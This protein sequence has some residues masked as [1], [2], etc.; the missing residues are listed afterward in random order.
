MMTEEYD[1][2]DG[3]R[4]W[5]SREEFARLLDVV[6]EPMRRVAFRLGAECGLRTE[7]IVEVTPDDVRDDPTVGT[8]LTVPDGKGGKLRE[9]P[10]PPSLA[11]LVETLGYGAESEAV[12]PRSTRSLRNWMVDARGRLLEDDSRWAFLTFHDLRRSW[13]GW[14]AV[15]EV[16]LAVALRWGGWD[17]LETFMSHYRSAATP[18]AQA[19]ERGRVSW[20]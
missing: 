13:A 8:Y 9:T 15:D 19:K 3:R 7:E 5:L 18:E 20:L 1:D 2:A 6:D 4:V 14:L 17:D 10:I 12:V 16:E 11:E